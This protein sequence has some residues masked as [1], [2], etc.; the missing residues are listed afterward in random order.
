MEQLLSVGQEKQL[1]IANNTFDEINVCRC[2]NYGWWLEQM[3]PLALL[4]C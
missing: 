1:A 2:G 4:Q 3:N